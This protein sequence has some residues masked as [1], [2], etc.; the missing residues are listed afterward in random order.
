MKSHSLGHCETELSSSDKA[1]RQKLYDHDLMARIFMYT[2]S[3]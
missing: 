2:C 1:R 3:S